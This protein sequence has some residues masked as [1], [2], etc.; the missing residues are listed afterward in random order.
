MRNK[1]NVM[2]KHL[3]AVKLPAQGLQPPPKAALEQNLPEHP[4]YAEDQ[5]G[6]AAPPRDRLEDPGVPRG[7]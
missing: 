5:R 6:E 7:D 1:G 4:G 3:L 2:Q